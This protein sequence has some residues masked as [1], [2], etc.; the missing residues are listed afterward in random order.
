MVD[1]KT[2]NRRAGLFSDRGSGTRFLIP[3]WLIAVMLALY[4]IGESREVLLPVILALLLALVFG[5]LAG[6]LQVRLKIPRFLAAL[7]IVGILGGAAYGG[8]YL[9]ADPVSRYVTKLRTDDAK[10]RI[11]EFV[12]PVREVQD[13]LSDMVEEVQ[14][15][16]EAASPDEVEVEVSPE[17]DG[18][19]N[20]VEAT[21]N[22]TDGQKNTEIETV[23]EEPEIGTPVRPVTVSVKEDMV[24]TLNVTAQEFGVAALSTMFLFLFLL[25]YGDLLAERIAE[26]WG[27]ASL[28]AAV[29]HDV[30]SYLCT[31]SV[32]NFFLGLAI[33]IALML[34]GVEDAY[35]WGIMAMFLNFIPYAGAVVGTLIVVLVSV[36][37]QQSLGMAFN[38]G[39]IYLG[40]SSIE[41]NMITP[42]IIGKRFAINPVVVFAW[43]LAWAA[44]WGLPGMLIGLPLLMMFRII[45]AQVPAL[46]K[47]ER[48]ISM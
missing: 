17:A 36:A 26:T 31:I 42:A 37:S 46:S 18:S 6:F 43:V 14:A 10:Q 23:I 34:I 4:F 44:L 35:L 39:V 30:S 21:V 13:D 28:L 15:L 8:G 20:D 45:C 40:L 1:P 25:A 48:A 32:I 19:T 2:P 11:A 3:L 7:L 38:A 5:P 29:K 12:A 22:V 27:S 41:G 33:G 16:P 47:I 24:S 9:L